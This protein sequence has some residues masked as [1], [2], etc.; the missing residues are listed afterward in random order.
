MFRAYEIDLDEIDSLIHKESTN[1]IYEKTPE[2]QSILSSIKHTVFVKKNFFDGQALLNEFFPQVECPV[3][4]SHS[5][6][7]ID[8]VRQFAHWLK[9]NFRINAFIDS[10]L[11]GGIEKL[12]TTMRNNINDTTNCSVKKTNK[13]PTHIHK[14]SLDEHTYVMLCHALTRT[15]NSTECFIFLK[16]S[17]STTTDDSKVTRSPWI[18]YELAAIDS[19]KIN[20][21][22]KIIDE[23]TKEP[24]L[25][26]INCE[27]LYSKNSTGIHLLTKEKLTEWKSAFEDNKNTKTPLNKQLMS[28]QKFYDSAP[29]ITANLIKNIDST[30]QYKN[31]KWAQALD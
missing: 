25:E 3:F 11:W 6:Q 27:V 9:N 29:S 1:S 18:F 5:G 17:N 2:I 26:S 13:K 24:L 31:S 20:N 15:I 22:R 28:D 23:T 19:I 12:Q 8:K 7:D 16:S 21:K 4:L 30:S 14:Y 10:D